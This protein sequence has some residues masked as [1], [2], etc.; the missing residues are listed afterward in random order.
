[1]LRGVAKRFPWH[2]AQTSLGAS[3][4]CLVLCS[5][6]SHN[7]V[8][9]REPGHLLAR[10]QQTLLPPASPRTGSGTG[11]CVGVRVSP[12]TQ[13]HASGS[14][15]CSCDTCWPAQAAL[16]CQQQVWK[17]SG[18]VLP[19]CLVCCYGRKDQCSPLRQRIGMI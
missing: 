9:H 15:L 11:R 10:A 6:L 12:S 2:Q 13:L 19:G 8:T 14:W 5:P 7:T 1:M 4:H 16:T 3:R 17:R 18:T